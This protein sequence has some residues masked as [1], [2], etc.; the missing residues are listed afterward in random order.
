MK[1]LNLFFLILFTSF[2]AFAGEPLRFKLKLTTAM[3][4]TLT[5]KYLSF[6]PGAC[7][8][9]EF[10]L[11]KPV[12]RK[13][14]VGM[15]FNPSS[16]KYS[17]NSYTISTLSTYSE[18]NYHLSYTNSEPDADVVIVGFEIAY[19]THF[20]SF[21]V[22]PFARIGYTDESWVYGMNIHKKKLND[23]YYQDIDTDIWAGEGFY[24]ALGVNIARRLDERFS[25]ELSLLM[26]YGSYSITN[27]IITNDLLG[28]RSWS[29]DVVAKHHFIIPQATI[30]FQYHFEKSKRRN[31]PTENLP[32]MQ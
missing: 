29:K 16:I 13:W 19:R 25:A 7:V 32:D 6:A 26:A 17:M 22:E 8:G 3:P 27:L 9:G 30:G 20:R 31:K 10:G 11:Y 23:N 1:H 24:P 18:N 12:S 28:S 5:G 14:T 2:N 4:L 21:D 15:Y